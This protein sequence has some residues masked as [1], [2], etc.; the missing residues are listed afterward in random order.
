[1]KTTDR[2]KLAIAQGMFKAKT[3]FTGGGYSMAKANPAAK[4]RVHQFTLKTIDGKDKS[5]ADYK[6]QTLLVVN[7]AS[8]CGL[9]PQYEAL[10][11]LQKKYGARGLRVLG[12]P[13]NEFGA[14]EPGSNEQIM[15]FCKMRFGVT[16]DMFAKIVVKGEG[17]HPLYRFLTTE[18]GFDGEIE[19]NFGKFLVD[20]DGTVVARFAPEEAPDSK[21]VLAAIETQLA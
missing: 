15:Q 17:I 6:G 3:L 16:F 2:L 20:R 12:F 13:A 21:T 14:Q 8:E 19:W 5:L 1:M 9:T 18:S 11:A 4:G 10:E 7:V